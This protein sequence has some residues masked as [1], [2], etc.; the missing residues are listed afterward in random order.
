MIKDAGDVAPYQQERHLTEKSKLMP[1]TISI[2]GNALSL[3]F[4]Q[5]RHVPPFPSNYSHEKQWPTRS[6]KGPHHK[7][8]NMFIEAKFEKLRQTGSAYRGLSLNRQ[9]RSKNQTNHVSFQLRIILGT[10]CP[11]L[12]G[13]S[14]LPLTPPSLV[15]SER[16]CHQIHAIQRHA[17]P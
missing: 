13:S 7:T 12:Y 3:K 5:R 1:R 14:G 17:T 9:A 15:G 11:M 6:G 4:L 16:F 2:R 10:A 8:A